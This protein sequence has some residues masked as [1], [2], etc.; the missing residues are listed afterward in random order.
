M[1]F[2]F[3]TWGGLLPRLYRR[4]WTASRL[5]AR[6]LPLSLSILCAAVAAGARRHRVGVGVFCVTSTFVS[7]A[8]P[9]IGQS[10]PASQAG[11]AMSAYNLVIF[12]GVFAVQWGIGLVIDALKRSAGRPCRRFRG[13]SRCSR[14]AALLSYVWFLWFRGDCAQAA[15]S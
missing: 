7:L 15:P 2:T 5:I 9:S 12:A 4:G 10:F 13:R 11:R 8:Q 1:L 14:C 3:M 6:G